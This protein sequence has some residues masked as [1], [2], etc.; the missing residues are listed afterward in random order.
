[1]SSITE[2]LRPPCS[3]LCFKNTLRTL[4]M[5]SACRKRSGVGAE[6]SLFILYIIFWFAESKISWALGCRVWAKFVTIV[7]ISSTFKYLIFIIMASV[8]KSKISGSSSTPKNTINL[9]NS[10]NDVG[11]SILWIIT[12]KSSY[13]NL[14]NLSFFLK[15]FGSFSCQHFSKKASAFLSLK[16]FLLIFDSMRDKICFWISGSAFES[17]ISFCYL[18]VS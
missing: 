14:K 12:L 18:R 10:T 17:R 7:R 3:Y 5:S 4:T 8:S 2:S 9:T 13:R 15:A 6:Y 16:N 11:L 1:M